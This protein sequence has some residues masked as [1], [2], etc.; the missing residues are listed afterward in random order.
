MKEVKNDSF[1]PSSQKP[2]IISYLWE[3]LTAQLLN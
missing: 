1:P 3:V 2:Q